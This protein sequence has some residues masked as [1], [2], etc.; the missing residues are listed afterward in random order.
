MATRN[1][2]FQCA[3]FGVDTVMSAQTGEHLLT[4]AFDEASSA[5]ATKSCA[6]PGMTDDQ[7]SLVLNMLMMGVDKAVQDVGKQGIPIPTVQGFAIQK[8]SANFT[9]S[10]D[11]GPGPVLDA[12]IDVVADL[13]VDPKA[14]LWQAPERLFAGASAG[15]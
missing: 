14:W 7:I 2:T 5:N 4:F 12:I 13:T 10:S 3:T 8:A 1:S 9:P 15:A 6:V 11:P